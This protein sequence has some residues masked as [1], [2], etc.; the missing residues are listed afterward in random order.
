MTDLE[1]WSP[2]RERQ[3]NGTEEYIAR[4]EQAI[5]SVLGLDLWESIILCCN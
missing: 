2:L 5:V 1:D 3:G 4:K